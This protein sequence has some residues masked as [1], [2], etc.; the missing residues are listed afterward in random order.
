MVGDNVEL[1]LVHIIKHI[2]TAFVQKGDDESKRLRRTEKLRTAAHATAA[3]TH[4]EL[5]GEHAFPSGE[6]GGGG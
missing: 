2:S 5:A 4:G 3:D 1:R 6:A